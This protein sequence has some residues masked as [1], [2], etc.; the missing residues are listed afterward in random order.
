[1]KPASE[2]SVG[3]FMWRWLR[4]TAPRV[5]LPA[6]VVDAAI[7]LGLFSWL[8]SHS[9]AIPFVA[10]SLFVAAFPYAQGVLYKHFIG[11]DTAEVVLR[12][13]EPVLAVSGEW[14]RRWAMR[15]ALLNLP[16]HAVAKLYAE[17]TNVDVKAAMR[18]EIERAGL[19]IRLDRAVEEPFNFDPSRPGA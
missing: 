5:L 2:M 16:L 14:G 11:G 15:A 13:A 18:A 10:L 6:L 3:E 12:V 19:Q 9:I 8:R 1:M 17:T 7:T 4:V